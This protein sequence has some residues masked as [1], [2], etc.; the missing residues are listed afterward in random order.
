LLFAHVDLAFHSLT[1]V[2]KITAQ[3]G[4]LPRC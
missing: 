4:N 1:T 3:A 2:I